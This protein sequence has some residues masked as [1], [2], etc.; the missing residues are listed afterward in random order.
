MPKPAPELA[1]VRPDEEM[2]WPRLEA[3]LVETLGDVEGPMR[4]LQFPGGHANLTY[5]V[6]FGDRE[7]VVRRPP[8]GPV[9]PGSHDMQREYTVLSKLWQVL[10]TAPR[11]YAF[12]GDEGVIGAPFLV[13]ERRHGVVVRS[14]I[15]DEMAHHADVE[16]RVSFALVDAMADL[17][18]VDPDAVGL[19]ELGRPKGFVLRQVEGWKSR[20]DRAKSE[21]LAAFDAVYERLRKSLPAPPSTSLVHNDLKLDNCQFEPANPDRVSAIFDW[22]M[23]TL[24]D[25]LVDL[26]TLLSYWPE[27]GDEVPR[28][29][30]VG[31]ARE[32]YPSRREISERYA[33]HTGATLE[34]IAWY[35]GFALWKAAV[36]LQQIYI[37]FA[38]GQTKDER[39]AALGG[40]VPRLVDCAAD[41]LAR[42]GA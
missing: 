13:M 7:L 33:G 25:P 20:W 19:S 6:R 2:D 18:A 32:G 34:A 41:V 30:T 22:D 1:P 10:P 39:F 36:V 38:R 37:R 8:L 15:P 16:R 40:H 29:P 31:A 42:S 3:W 5:C 24:G 35:E 12:C 9:A 23:T 27:P 11:A 26:G 17:H 4:V 14:A 21:D 28:S